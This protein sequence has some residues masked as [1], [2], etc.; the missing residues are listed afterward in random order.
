M[1]IDT[2]AKGTYVYKLQANRSADTAGGGT[3]SASNVLIAA[4]EM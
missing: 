1:Y 3:A 2:P 4:E